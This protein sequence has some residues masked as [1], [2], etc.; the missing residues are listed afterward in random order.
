MK[1]LKKVFKVNDLKVNLKFY[2]KIKMIF[3]FH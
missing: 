3:E 2:G 1:T